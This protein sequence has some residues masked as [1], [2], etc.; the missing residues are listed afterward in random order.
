MH[1]EAILKLVYR[2]FSQDAPAIGLERA[3]ALY[4]GREKLREQAVQERCVKASLPQLALTKWP[5]GQVSKQRTR[6]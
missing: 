1:Q 5:N 4:T 2:Q 6:F 3:H